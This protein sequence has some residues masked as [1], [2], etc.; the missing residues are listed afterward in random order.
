MALFCLFKASYDIVIL[1]EH[2]KNQYFVKFLGFVKMAKVFQ[3]MEEVEE[4]LKNDDEE[5]DDQNVSNKE[6][7][8]Q[9]TVS[10]R[11]QKKMI[12]FKDDFLMKVKGKKDEYYFPLK[13]QDL[14]VRHEHEGLNGEYES[15][16]EVEMT[17]REREVM[18]MLDAEYDRREVENDWDQDDPTSWWHKKFITKAGLGRDFSVV[19]EEKSKVS[20]KS[21][22]E[23]EDFASVKQDIK[24]DEPIILTPQKKVFNFDFIRLIAFTFSISCLRP[25]SMIMWMNVKKFLNL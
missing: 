2:I 11:D 8:D 12:F 14:D 25:F 9:T 19:E 24:E 10:L 22:G 20:S 23:N 16:D 4:T 6:E 18:E 17:E 3:L 7:E 21:S 13:Y 15:D 1:K 5:E